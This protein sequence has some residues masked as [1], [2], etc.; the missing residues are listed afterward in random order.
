[1]RIPSS[2]GFRSAVPQTSQSTAKVDEN[3]ALQE[4]QR[5][6]IGPPQLHVSGTSD[7]KSSNQRWAD[8]H[9]RQN[10]VQWPS[11]L[12]RSSRSQSAAL[13]TAKA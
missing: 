13:P 11:T 12:R 8:P 1:M 4:G 10:A 2:S 6:S 9:R 5:R 3:G 7:S